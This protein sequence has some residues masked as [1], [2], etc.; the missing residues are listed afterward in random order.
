MAAAGGAAAGLVAAGLRHAS[1]RARRKIPRR[2]QRGPLN[3]AADICQ[4]SSTGGAPGC[5]H[6]HFG[7]RC[8]QFIA[9]QPQ[10]PA[11]ALSRACARCLRA[12]LRRAGKQKMYQGVDIGR[13]VPLDV[14]P[15]GEAANVLHVHYRWAARSP[16]CPANA[17]HGCRSSRRTR[18]VH[19][20]HCRTAAWAAAAP[21]TLHARTVRRSGQPVPKQGPTR[22]ACGQARQRGCSLMLL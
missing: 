11:S 3:C 8:T 2:L 18:G 21:E 4:G 7:S 15:A 1:R 10:Q 14:L 12:A 22:A 19:V 17:A 5:L 16:A 9:R 6:R 13:S 20:A